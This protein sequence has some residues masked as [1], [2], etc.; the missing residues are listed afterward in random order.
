MGNT[1]DCF[2][3]TRQYNQCFFPCI[4]CCSY[5]HRRIFYNFDGMEMVQPLVHFY[6]PKKSVVRKFP[7]ELESCAEEEELEQII[8]NGKYIT[9]ILLTCLFSAWNCA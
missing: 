5:S 3:T 8:K 2:Y 7:G 4:R 1:L 9:G 6:F